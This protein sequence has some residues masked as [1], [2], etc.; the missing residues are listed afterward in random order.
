MLCAPEDAGG[1]GSG[2]VSAAP[3]AA[4]AAP[5]TP[6]TP[7]AAGERM[8]TQAE[9]NAIVGDRLARQRAEQ[10][11][12]APRAPAA[13]PEPAKPTDVAAELAQMKQRALFADHA[14]DYSIPRDRRQDM[15][16]L[17]AA[18]S[19][20]DP[21]A[22]FAQKAPIFGTSTPAQPAA[23]T[24]SSSIT[25]PPASPPA[26]PAPPPAAP[27]A[28]AKVDHLASGG[29]VDIFKLTPAEIDSL[30]PTG[31]RELHERALTAAKQQSGAPPL[32]RQ[33]QSKR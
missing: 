12:Q 5:T 3:A 19:P 23:T 25:A 32:P 15:Y 29:L 30:G 22:W 28:P 20:A 14:A 26:P 11:P 31:I 27:S 18:Q 24:T 33:V 17:F 1:G 13:A 10:Q 2:G 21:A 16:D 6:A 7:P 8:F 4:A 9:V